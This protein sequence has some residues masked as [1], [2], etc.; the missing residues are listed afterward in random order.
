M[1]HVEYS[2]E[3]MIVKLLKKIQII[4]SSAFEIIIEKNGIEKEHS[5]V[6]R[7]SCDITLLISETGWK[8]KYDI[9][10]GFRL[11]VDSSSNNLI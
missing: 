10:I 9:D 8:P 2:I 11:A 5:G 6:N 3:F 4:I 1:V 7:P